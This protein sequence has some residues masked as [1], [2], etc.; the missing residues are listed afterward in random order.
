[1]YRRIGSAGNAADLQCDIDALINWNVRNALDLNVAKCHISLFSKRDSSENYTYK[2]NDVQISRVESIKDVGV[3]LDSKLR[4]VGHLDFICSKV[5]K[6]LGVLRKFI[7]DF[8]NYSVILNLYKSLVL[9]IFLHASPVWT[10][11]L[12]YEKDR[13]GSVQHFKSGRPMHPHD[14]DY[15]PI[16]NRFKIPSLSSQPTL[17]EGCH[18]CI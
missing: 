6:V 8:R 3:H 12:A 18:F 13:L 9:P 4:Y 11:Y 5:S 15:S 7:S 1:M 14:H 16:M 10:L 17:C 2:I